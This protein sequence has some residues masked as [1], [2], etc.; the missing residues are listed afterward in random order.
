MHGS[1]L[2]ERN[3]R[4]VGHGSQ[5]PVLYRRVRIKRPGFGDNRTPLTK[6]VGAICILKLLKHVVSAHPFSTV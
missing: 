4:V 2:R 3:V 6:G 1:W 5:L